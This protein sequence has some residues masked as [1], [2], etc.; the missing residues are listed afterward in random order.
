MKEPFFFLWGDV[1]PFEQSW[2]KAVL[3]VLRLRTADVSIASR[4]LFQWR[5]CAHLW[6]SYFPVADSGLGAHHPS[7]RRAW[8]QNQFQPWE[9]QEVE[10]WLFFSFFIL[11]KTPDHEM[12]THIPD[13]V[14]PLSLPSLTLPKASSTNALS[15]S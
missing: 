9:D 12:V 7:W 14:L 15:V 2:A 8:W 11:L 6:V 3:A 10:I 4:A 5:S 13:G 1:E